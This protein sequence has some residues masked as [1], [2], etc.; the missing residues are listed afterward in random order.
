MI[1]LP[2][3]GIGQNFLNQKQPKDTLENK[4]K[5]VQT[6]KPESTKVETTYAPK[7]TTKAIKKTIQ[8]TK[9]KLTTSIK[10]PTTPQTKKEVSVNTTSKT[11]TDSTLI[12][13]KGISFAPS[14]DSLLQKNQK[15][16]VTF[17][18]DTTLDSTTTKTI[19]DYTAGYKLKSVG[20]EKIDFS[21]RTLEDTLNSLKP[22]FERSFVDYRVIRNEEL[23]KLLGGTSKYKKQQGRSTLLADV[24]EMFKY[25]NDNEYLASTIAFLS[26]NYGINE[27]TKELIEGI[28]LKKD[29]TGKIV[30]IL[31]NGKLKELLPK[32][33]HDKNGH[34]Y[35]RYV[36]NEQDLNRYK[37]KH[38]DWFDENGN[39]KGSIVPILMPRVMQELYKEILKEKTQR[40]ILIREKEKVTIENKVK[41]YVKPKVEQKEKKPKVIS[42][43]KLKELHG[44][45]ALSKELGLIIGKQGNTL[46][47]IYGNGFGSLKAL[48]I[49]ITPYTGFKGLFGTNNLNLAA[50]VGIFEGLDIESMIRAGGNIDVGRYNI[51]AGITNNPI[52]S[53]GEAAKNQLGLYLSLILPKIT[54]TD[55][56]EQLYIPSDTNDIKMLKNK[57]YKMDTTKISVG[58]SINAIDIN[59]Y[60][61][62]RLYAGL[63]KNPSE[64]GAYIGLSN[65]S[66]EILNDIIA[67][68]GVFKPQDIL[69]GI[70]SGYIINADYINRNTSERN[71]SGIN[72]SGLVGLGPVNLFANYEY[73]NS[74]VIPHIT[75]PNGEVVELDPVN[76]K[77]SGEVIGVGINYKKFGGQIIGKHEKTETNGVS[78][79]NKGVEIRAGYKF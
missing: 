25:G 65:I 19:E 29:K 10:K 33:S 9:K 18:P 71:G 56:T 35:F 13:L 68:R 69:P 40:T 17:K 12:K 22:I 58:D 14:L 28:E 51:G 63:E 45:N 3:F 52:Y 48:N 1:I 66:Q 46:L 21:A 42:L 59:K 41:E 26:K 70:R 7:D 36:K 62:G 20:I 55:S 76:I 23:N 78:S 50:N 11:I 30:D 31:V 57:G 44:E 53:K 72:L 34:L 73:N 32:Y 43:K 8:K 74:D 79:S 64:F 16:E 15:L 60:D 49:S 24:F 2:L 39:L 5:Q 38:K 37:K 6:V 4:T 54:K 27:W 67:S 61:L 47:G 75:L 77:Y